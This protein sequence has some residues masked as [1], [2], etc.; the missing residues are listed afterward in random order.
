MDKLLNECEEIIRWP[1]KPS[2]KDLVIIYL[3]SKF[4]FSK[5]YTEKQ[6]NSII[7]K[8]HTFNDI[9][10]LR[11]ELVSRKILS[12]ENDGSVYWKVE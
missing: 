3:G 11:R 10:L 7:S 12:R 1:K 2:D 6:V 4:N 8:Y 9:P 5:T